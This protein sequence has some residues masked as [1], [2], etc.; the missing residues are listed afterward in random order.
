MKTGGAQT[1]DYSSAV[2]LSIFV[3]QRKVETCLRDRSRK[4]DDSLSAS[5]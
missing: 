3:E 1:C 5:D 4:S 2:S